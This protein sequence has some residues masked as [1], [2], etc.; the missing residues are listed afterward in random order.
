MIGIEK[1]N[2]V[3]CLGHNVRGLLVMAFQGNISHKQNV[4]F[5]MLVPIWLM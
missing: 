4:V 5:A 2:I 1:R 3:K